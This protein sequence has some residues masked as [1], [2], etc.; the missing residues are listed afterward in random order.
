MKHAF[1]PKHYCSVASSGSVRLYHVAI[2]ELRY[3][4]EANAILYISL[5]G[6]FFC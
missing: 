2:V 6:F 5:F 1:R 4:E 3:T